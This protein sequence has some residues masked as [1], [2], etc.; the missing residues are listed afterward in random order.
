MTVLAAFWRTDGPTGSVDELLQDP[1]LAHYVSG[2]P[3]PGDLGVVAETDQP[4]GAAWLRY[5]TAD[6]P[7]FGFID[8]AIPEVAIGVVEQWRGRGVGRRLLAALIAAA[9]D[10]DIT[11]VSLSVETDNYALGLY[12][13]LGFQRVA[14]VG[15]AVTMRLL[16]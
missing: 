2:W 7:G 3:Q 12:E 4:V 15:G 11:A 6:D 14:H 16:L 13:G 10:A 9:R 1:Q 8:P 5:F